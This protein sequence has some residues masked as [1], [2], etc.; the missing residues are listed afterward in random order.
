MVLSTDLRIE[1]EE[2]EL[3]AFG[4]EPVRGVF[5]VGPRLIDQGSGG[6]EFSDDDEV[7]EGG[8]F[9][10]HSDWRQFSRAS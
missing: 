8:L 1:L 4:G 9:L 10:V 7:V 2:F 3:V 6:V 5:A